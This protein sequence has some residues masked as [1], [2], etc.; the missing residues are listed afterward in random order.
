MRD[1]KFSIDKI[2]RDSINPAQSY[3]IFRGYKGANFINC[4]F[5]VTVQGVQNND[6]SL[7]YSINGGHNFDHCLFF[8][9]KDNST[10]PVET[11]KFLKIADIPKIEYIFNR[12]Y[13]DNGVLK[14]FV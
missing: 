8:G 2:A 12:L 11:N 9:T 7:Y 4:L 14:L 10:S 1:C 13:T 5:V 3:N 6:E